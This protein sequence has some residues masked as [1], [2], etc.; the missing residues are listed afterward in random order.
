MRHMAD[1]ARILLAC[2]RLVNGLAALVVPQQL[3]RGLGID[4]EQYP[5][6]MYVLR[7]FGM[8]TVLIGLDLL[9]PRGERR[10]QALKAAPII[11]ASD[12]AAA[13]LAGQNSNF[14][15]PM[16]RITV[17]ISAINTGLALIA[18]R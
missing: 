4:P 2:I 16:A 6:A 8:R 11:H 9:A 12:T 14:P 17:V 1:L 10:E 7:M 18:N 3:A 15:Q 13:F 5:A